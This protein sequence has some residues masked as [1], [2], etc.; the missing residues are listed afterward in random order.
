MYE[1]KIISYN[2]CNELHIN[3]GEAYRRYFD[4]GEPEDNSFFRDY[5]WIKDEL[6]AAYKKGMEDGQNV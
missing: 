6:E 5:K 2:D 3:I 4:H 1:I